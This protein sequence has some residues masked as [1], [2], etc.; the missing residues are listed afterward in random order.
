MLTVIGSVLT[1]IGCALVVA[2]I[3]MALPR[4]ARIIVVHRARSPETLLKERIIAERISRRLRGWGEACSRRVRVA[5]RVITAMFSRWYRRLR[6]IAHEY[7]SIRPHERGAACNDFIGQA[8]R[9]MEEGGDDRAE[10][11][12]LAC[13]KVDPKHRD[14]YLGLSELYCK[15]KEFGLA[16][17]TLRFLRKLVPADLEVVA[18]FAEVLRERGKNAAALREI[19]AALRVAPRNP[20]YL[21]F[22]LELAI[23]ER[24]ARLASLFLEQLREANPENQKL[25]EFSRRITEI[26]PR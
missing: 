8:Q 24:D 26:G 1:V 3:V 21:D 13:L 14:A 17:E 9:A 18:S 22:A 12:F 6:I 11:C 7:V 19:Q 20:R 5:S 4:I 10:E 25:E 16:E 15:R 2:V 23:M